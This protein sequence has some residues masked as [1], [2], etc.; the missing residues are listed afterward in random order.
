MKAE[1]RLCSGT[2]KQRELVE[3]LRTRN[4]LCPA[5]NGTAQM[6]CGEWK[7]TSAAVE[8]EHFLKHNQVYFSSA[9]QE[10]FLDIFF[11]VASGS[12]I[13]SALGGLH[14]LSHQG[15]QQL[16]REARHKDGVPTTSLRGV[17]EAHNM[18]ETLDLVAAWYT[19]QL[20]SGLHDTQ[21][22]LDEAVGHPIYVHNTNSLM[23]QRCDLGGAVQRMSHWAPL[24]EDTAFV[25][26]PWDVER[27]CYDFPKD[28]FVYPWLELNARFGFIPKVTDE[29]P[30]VR[31]RSASDTA[32]PKYGEVRSLRSRKSRINS[33]A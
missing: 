11:T 27:R 19:R 9:L 32:H 21:V 17:V 15:V 10:A 25:T 3:G 13:F 24:K 26:T 30:P 8:L 23:L 20:E 28:R 29:L 31:Q 33:E 2:P 5:A 4:F 16:W 1:S 7:I 18:P 6:T 12:G 22:A 14:S